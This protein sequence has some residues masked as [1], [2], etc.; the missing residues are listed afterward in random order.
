MPSISPT[1]TPPPRDPARAPAPEPAR[2]LAR[3]L[4]R[5]SDRIVALIL[6]SD[7]PWIDIVFEIQA[8]RDLV[9]TEAPDL[10]GAFERIYTARFQRIRDQWRES[11][12]R[13]K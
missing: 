3:E 7:L 5:R 4:S 10:A 11:S 8:M 12:D 6:Y 1:P 2:A 13:A 9:E